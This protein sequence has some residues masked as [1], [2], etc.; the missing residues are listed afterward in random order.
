MVEDGDG[1]V[2]VKDSLFAPRNRKSVTFTLDPKQQKLPWKIDVYGP[3]TILW[4][5]EGD[6]L[7][8]GPSDQALEAIVAA[9]K[10][11]P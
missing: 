7:F 6:Q 5:G 2:L 9:M 11:H 10:N 8:L 3:A 4:K 1:K